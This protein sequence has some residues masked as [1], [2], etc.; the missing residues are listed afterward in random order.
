MA[1]SPGAASLSEQISVA[2]SREDMEALQQYCK[3]ADESVGSFVRRATL[4][5]LAAAGVFQEDKA[6][7][8]LLLGALVDQSTGHVEP[9]R[10]P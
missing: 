1:K 4:E 3:A 2:F 10:R 6:R 5:K 7:E 8:R 9:N